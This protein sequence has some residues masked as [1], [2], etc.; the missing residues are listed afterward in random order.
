MKILKQKIKGVFLIKP[1]PIKDIRGMFRRHF[2]ISE[3]KKYGI[4]SSVEQANI[5]E[6]PK[7]GTLRGLHFHR[8]THQEAKT[9]F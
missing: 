2:C 1:E 3:L 7:K 9:I 4:S 8:E 5:S 6:N